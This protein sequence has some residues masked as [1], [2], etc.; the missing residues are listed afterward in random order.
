MSDRRGRSSTDRLVETALL[1]N[2]VI[3]GLALAVAASRPWSMLFWPNA[4]YGGLLAALAVALAMSGRALVVQRRR[5]RASTRLGVVLRFAVCALVL[6]AIPWF[7]WVQPFKALWLLMYAG[8]SAGVVSAAWSLLP[9]L[10][11]RLPRR[12]GRGVDLALFNL[13]ALVLLA[14]FALR[15]IAAVHP[16][17]LLA[18][19]ELPSDVLARYRKAPGE[20]HLGYACDQRGCNDEL[21]RRPGERLVVCLGDSFSFGLVPRPL[22]YTTVAER[23]L[24]QTEI[25]NAGVIAAGPAEYLR[26][27]RDDLLPLRPDALV[28]ALFLGN[29]LYEAARFDARW[30]SLAGIFDRE[31]LM[32]WVLPRRLATLAHE[33]QQRAAAGDTRAIGAIQGDDA[34]AATA[35][36]ADLATL[37]AR[38]P[39]LE[40]PSAEVGTMSVETFLAIERRRAEFFRAPDG[41]PL[42]ER[43]F[44]ALGALLDAAGDLPVACLLIPDE[45]QIE[46][47]LWASVGSQVEDRDRPQRL[48]S[49]WLATRRVP[50]LDLLPVLRAVAPSADG[51]RHLYH[52]R[53]TH[54]NRRGNEVAGRA[55]AGFLRDWLPR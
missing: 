16:S 24:E 13:C 26:L 33:R 10:A 9:S 8:V 49:A 21:A 12:L 17:P 27:L 4:G 6:A 42:Y 23:A 50:L 31:R 19:G 11:S 35:A 34:V 20:L 18:V 5:Q 32:L 38:F 44:A 3:A 22:H 47:E 45:F 36:Q 55:L 2:A 41:D 52:L 1:G 15:G 51:R 48:I 37:S 28:I 53:D 43:F 25:Y 14:E 40:D 39:W 29:D 7:V 54:W 30:S 46:D